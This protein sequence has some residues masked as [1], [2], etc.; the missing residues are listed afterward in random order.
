VREFELIDWI[1][2]RS[3]PAGGLVV[4]G[5]GDDAAVL[6]LRT[7]GRAVVTTDLILESTHF[8][9]GDD[10]FDVGYKAMA[11]SVSDVAAMG[12]RSVAGFLAVGLRRD[13]GEEY[14]KRL[15]EGA[16][17]VCREAGAALAGGDTTESRGGTVLCSTVVGAVPPGGEPILRSGARP[18]EAVFVTGRLGGS[19]AGRH[20]RFAPRQAEALA[21]VAG[22][23]VGAMIDLSDGLSSDAGHVARAS[24][25]R[26]LLLADRIPISE[27]ARSAADG[28]SALSRAL[29]DG[30]DFE[31][32]FTAPHERAAALERDGLAGTPVTRIG[33]VR[34]GEGVVLRS[35]DGREA[36]LEAG[37]YEHFR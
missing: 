10:P 16:L 24:G 17:A 22:G 7:D 3:G 27:A 36:P 21:L 25:V 18:G 35:A 9:A 20:L 37:G 15:F 28:R 34:A 5:I 4:L 19:L 6:D 13:R 30:E 32:L 8:L 33:E 29:D 26:L 1:R 11:V 23:R 12:C 2:G 14:A 31:L